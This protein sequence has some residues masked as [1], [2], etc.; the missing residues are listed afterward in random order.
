MVLE[1]KKIRR[2]EYKAA[3]KIQSM[4]RGQI[5][6]KRYQ[7]MKG[8]RLEA[9]VR[10]QRAWRNYVRGIIFPKIIRQIKD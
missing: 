2:K 8:Q 1:R 3:V 10:I 9:V 5:V 4:V 6:W 7:K